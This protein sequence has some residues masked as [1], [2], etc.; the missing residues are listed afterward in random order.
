MSVVCYN[1]SLLLGHVVNFFRRSW[2]PFD[3]LSL[4]FRG[5]GAAPVHV[6]LI[7][8]VATSLSFLPFPSPHLVPGLVN[9]SASVRVSLIVR[10]QFWW[11]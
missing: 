3:S 10:L 6:E 7:C 4:S 11:F 9:L 1:K 8:T 2:L 5:W